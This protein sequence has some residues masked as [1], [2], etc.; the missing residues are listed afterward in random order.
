MNPRLGSVVGKMPERRG[1]MKRDHLYLDQE[2]EFITLTTDDCELFDFIEDYLEEDHDISSE[3]SR[4]DD[5]LR[6]YVM[7]FSK[8]V[9]VDRLKSVLNAI[10]PGEIERIWSLNNSVARSQTLGGR[11]LRRLRHWVFHRV[12]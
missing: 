11:L 4:H 2:G 12:I 5:D 1:A 3:F 9:S 8:S 10:D 6:L 7:Y